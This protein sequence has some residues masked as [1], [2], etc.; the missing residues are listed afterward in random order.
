M[1]NVSYFLSFETYRKYID[2]STESVKWIIS[3][4]QIGSAQEIAYC[5]EEDLLEC[6]EGKWMALEVGEGAELTSVG[7]NILNEAMLKFVNA[8]D[9]RIEKC[10]AILDLDLG[11]GN[12]I[13]EGLIA[14]IIVLVLVV[15]V[16]LFGYCLFRRAYGSGKGM[17]AKE[18]VKDEEEDEEAGKQKKTTEIDEDNE[19]A[20][21]AVTPQSV[22]SN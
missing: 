10:D 4:N 13:D 18:R 15:V 7:D 17:I 11:Q 21:M 22:A 5:E 1:T 20:E 6:G 3:K 14:G 16:I 12:G 2:D 8:T 9:M 19:T